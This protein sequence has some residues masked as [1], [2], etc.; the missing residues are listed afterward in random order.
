MSPNDPVV[1]E[2]SRLF[3]EQLRNRPEQVIANCNAL[4][5]GD[6]IRLDLVYTR[7]TYENPAEASIFDHLEKGGE[8]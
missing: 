8:D 7:K 6:G 4:V 5:E 2:A 1:Q 3:I